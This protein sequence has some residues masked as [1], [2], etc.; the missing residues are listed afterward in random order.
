[1]A[2]H[3]RQ[4]AIARRH[5]EERRFSDAVR[6]FDAALAAVVDGR[7]YAELAT[8]AQAAGDPARALRAHLDT[9]G[10]TAERDLVTGAQ[11]A[12]VRLGVKPRTRACT[13]PLPTIDEVC[14][15]LI[16]L[17]GH[18]CSADGYMRL[19]EGFQIVDHEDHDLRTTSKLLTARA[20]NGGWFV[21]AE[22]DTLYGA[23]QRALVRRA[24]IKKI[25]DHLLLWLETETVLAAPTEA[26][27]DRTLTICLVAENAAP[28]CPLSMPILHERTRDDDERRERW[29]LHLDI[30]DEGV[31]TTTVIAGTAAVAPPR[32]LW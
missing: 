30:D 9:L 16:K 11:A 28:V 25:A 6:A 32:R 22:L 23:T 2:E 17:G 24:A 3:R 7:V 29:V 12:L 1:M 14:D 21:A 13:S 8:A 10:T 19:P 20:P 5:A 15:C 18:A 31:A 26:A 4:L 27:V